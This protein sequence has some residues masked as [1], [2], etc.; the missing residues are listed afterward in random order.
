MRLQMLTP[1]YLYNFEHG[2]DD[3]DPIA[4]QDLISFG[5]STAVTQ[6]LP[7]GG[8]DSN[9]WPQQAKYA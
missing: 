9:D 1:I 2:F 4:L 3:P 8:L 7:I 6:V 5:N